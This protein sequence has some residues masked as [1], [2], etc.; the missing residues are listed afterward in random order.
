MTLATSTESQLFYSELADDPDLAEIVEL[1]VAEM[2]GRVANLEA[3]FEQ[4]QWAELE[5]AAHQIKGAA[6]SYGFNQLTPAA[7]RLEAVVRRF[8]DEGAIREALE[9]L[10]RFCRGVRGGTAS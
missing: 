7:A 3:R 10:T 6:G 5:R 2:P 1:F 9:A 4:R 8:E